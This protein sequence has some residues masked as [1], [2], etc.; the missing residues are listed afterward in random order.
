MNRNPIVHEA[1]Q[2]LCGRFEQGGY[3]PTV[4]IDIGVLIANADGV[5][6]ANEIEAL[7]DIFSAL[8]STQLSN[9]LVDHLVQA[10]LT[11][12]REAGVESRVR[13]IAEILHDCNA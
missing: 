3:N 5:V 11:V 8:L 2:S 9:E 1:V 10:S 13:L 7:A 12:I 4:V 6:D